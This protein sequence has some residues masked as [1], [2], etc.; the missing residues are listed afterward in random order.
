MT[1]SV[2]IDNPAGRLYAIFTNIVNTGERLRRDNHTLTLL[3]VLAN[4]FEVDENN[5]EGLKALGKIFE[6]ID[7]TEERIKK[8]QNIDTELYLSPLE[9]IADAFVKIDMS[10]TFFNLASLGIDKKTLDKLKFCAYTLSREQ[11]EILLSA[12]QLNELLLEVRE[13]LDKVLESEL[14]ADIK[15]FL[16]ERLRDIEQ[17]IINYKFEGSVGLRKVL[18]GTIG[19]LILSG[20]VK[21]QKENPL[22]TR[23]FTVVTRLAALLNIANTSKQ[24]TPDVFNIV[25]KLLPGDKFK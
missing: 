21:E 12:E 2:P 6:L 8:L 5:R 14:N 3:K 11:G 10:S 17:A 15:Q 7:S 25:S 18:E 16:I 22:V 9:E 20:N 19:A 4:A 24:L 1:T 13:L 23:F